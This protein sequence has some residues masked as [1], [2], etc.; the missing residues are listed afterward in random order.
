MQT[1]KYDA[2][3]QQVSFGKELT[4]TKLT[5]PG[6]GETFFKLVVS[7][8]SEIILG[9]DIPATEFNQFMGWVNELRE[10]K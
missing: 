9:I 10:S 6:S 5:D 4:I 3:N 7:C 2:E 8:G 1:V